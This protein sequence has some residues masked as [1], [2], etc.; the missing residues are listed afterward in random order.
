MSVSDACSGLPDIEESALR[1]TFGTN[2][3]SGFAIGPG[4]APTTS[5]ADVVQQW[6]ADLN[7]VAGDAALHVRT[8]DGTQHVLGSKV[9]IGTVSPVSTLHVNGSL[10]LADSNAVARAEI[11]VDTTAGCF[12]EAGDIVQAI[13][14]GSISEA[15]IR[16]ELRDLVTGEASG[17]ESDDAITLFKSVG[18]AV[19]DLAAA[20]LAFRNHIQDT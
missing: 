15:D 6:V 11:Y 9:G 1:T 3:V 16:G 5:P 8:E 13:N 4:T 18:T 17:R 20:E 12:S 10:R 2:L 19:E 14:D 7:G